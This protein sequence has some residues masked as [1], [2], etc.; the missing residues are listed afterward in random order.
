MNRRCDQFLASARLPADQHGRIGSRHLVDLLV[1][2]AHGPRVA[3][4]IVR[5]E[6]F[7]KGIAE[8]AIFVLE[9]LPF[10]AREPAGSHVE[11]DQAGND[12]E[13]ACLFF[14][15]ALLLGS[16]VGRQGSNHF[17]FEHDGDAEKAGLLGFFRMAPVDPILK[18][19]FLRNARDDLGLSCLEDGPDDSLPIPVA[20]LSGFVDGAAVGR[21]EDQLLA[22]GG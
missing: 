5:S 12:L 1:H 3:D 18:P 10:H 20:D 15:V 2:T 7:F 4:D 9:H 14:E 21:L 19:R 22:I 6:S 16:Y 17:A 13:Y 11:G 8:A